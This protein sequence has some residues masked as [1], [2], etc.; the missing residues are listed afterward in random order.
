MLSIPPHDTHRDSFPQTNSI[1]PSLH[2]PGAHF[3]HLNTFERHCPMNPKVPGL[4]PQLGLLLL[5]VPH[6]LG[7][8]KVT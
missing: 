3:F 8:G 5:P 6:A 2:A 1:F 7:G 4:R